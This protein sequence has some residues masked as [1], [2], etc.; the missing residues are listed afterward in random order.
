VKTPRVSIGLPVYNGEEF[1][2]QA[3]DALL[4]Q[5]FRDFELI[6]CDNASTD[7][8]PEIARNYAARDSRVRFCRNEEN[9][10]L[11][12]NLNRTVTES[13]GEYF[14]WVAHD[15]LWAPQ[16][17]E[18]CVAALDADPGLVIVC[19]RTRDIDEHGEFLPAENIYRRNTIP[20]DGLA[21][22]DAPHERFR[23]MIG[24]LH[25]CE[26]IFGVMRAGVLKKT[27][28][29]GR[30]ADADRVLL[31]ELALYGRFQ[32]V[33]EVL[34]YHR[35]HTN[36]SVLVAPGR[37]E[38]SVILDPAN[39]GK[40]LYPH[41]KELAEFAGAVRRSPVAFGQRLRCYAH[42]LGWSFEYRRRLWMD[43]T[44]ATRLILKRILPLSVQ[45]TIKRILSPQ[46]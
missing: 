25:V 15:D 13:S 19:T 42:L 17:L 3:L 34:F 22:E 35:E 45:K 11:A 41:F 33:P 46:S 6:V 4:A 38:R 20:V 1:L 10:G 36:R 8:S 40:I 12:G 31:A 16:H 27:P 32:V 9:I 39:A 5:T 21:V 29:H 23:D 14:L 7:R 2:S 30:Y 43:I 37:H 28:L 44:I 24:L 18:R 26:P